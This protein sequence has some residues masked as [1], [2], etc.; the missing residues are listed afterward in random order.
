MPTILWPHPRPNATRLRILCPQAG[1]STVETV[2]THISAPGGKTR[3]A[4][5]SGGPLTPALR[6]STLR[7]ASRFR[8]LRRRRVVLCLAGFPGRTFLGCVLVGGT[9]PWAALLVGLSPGRGVSPWSPF[10]VSPRFSVRS[11]SR[12]GVLVEGRPRVNIYYCNINI[13]TYTS[14]YVV[15]Q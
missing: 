4:V 12:R 14:I 5:S 8:G 2:L 1:G 9:N 10:F 3:L 7:C 13:Y 6:C 15:V 11:G